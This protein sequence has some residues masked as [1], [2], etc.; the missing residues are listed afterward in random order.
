M[1]AVQARVRE[2]GA[3]QAVATYELKTWQDWK[4]FRWS[5]LSLVRIKVLVLSASI[6]E[7]WPYKLAEIWI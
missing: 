7:D 4:T 5:R 3:Q 6:Y 1:E 2:L